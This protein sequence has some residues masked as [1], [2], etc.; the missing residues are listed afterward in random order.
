[1]LEFQGGTSQFGTGISFFSNSTLGIEKVFCSFRAELQVFY[2][3][4][5]R[6]ILASVVGRFHLCR[7]SP[8]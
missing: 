1:M 2:A 8:F 3:S 5:G 4:K 6:V 7:P